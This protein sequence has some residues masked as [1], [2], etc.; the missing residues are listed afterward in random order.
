MNR[1]RARVDRNARVEQLLHEALE[2]VALSRRRRR[3]GHSVYGILNYT[4]QLKTKM[5]T[6]ND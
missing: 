5:G 2:Q 3:L 6:Q 1:L 4:S